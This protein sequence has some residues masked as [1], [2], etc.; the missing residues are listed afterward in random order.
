MAKTW[1]MNLL[2]GLQGRLPAVLNL[3]LFKFSGSGGEATKNYG[4]WENESGRQI[5]LVIGASKRLPPNRAV[6]ILFTIRIWRKKNLPVFH[7][8]LVI[9][10][11]SFAIAPGR[12][13]S[14]DK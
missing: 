13:S 5:R 1:P 2:T 3:T 12:K 14:A 7:F 6:V 9:L 4:D 11:L 10:R 8:P